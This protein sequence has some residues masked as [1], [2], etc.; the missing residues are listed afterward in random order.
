MEPTPGLN[1]SPVRWLVTGFL[2]GAGLIGLIW[3]MVARGPAPA[4][5]SAQAAPPAAK[6][7]ET[8]QAEPTPSRPAISESARGRTPAAASLT[9]QPRSVGSREV[10]APAR[11][12]PPASQPA[13]EPV[14]E[15]VPEPEPEPPADPLSVRINVNTATASELQALPGIGPVLSGR[16]VYY[17]A[18]NG[19]FRSLRDLTEVSGIGPKTAEKLAPYVKFD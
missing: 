14:P 10:E 1:A 11:E 8:F 17:R 9:A 4:T 15:P 3:A 12:P 16:V 7:V 2:G 5:P 19:P 6:P 13:R 18:A